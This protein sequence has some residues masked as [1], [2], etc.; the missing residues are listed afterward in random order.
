M[1]VLDSQTKGDLE[2]A[3]KYYSRAVQADPRDGQVVSQYAQLVWEL[4][5]DQDKAASYFEQSVEV[6][7]ANRYNIPFS[8]LF[9]HVI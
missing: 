5:H 6:A 1:F 9:L 2:G 4:H 8:F 3:E 7:P